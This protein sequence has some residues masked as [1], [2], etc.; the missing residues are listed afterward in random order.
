MNGYKADI[1]SSDLNPTVFTA[2]ASLM[3]GAA[4]GDRNA[5]KLIRLIDKDEQISEK[6]AFPT[7]SSTRP[8]SLP[9]R[10]LN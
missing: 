9:T 7:R 3:G 8:Q 1:L 4:N 5:E 2:R 6:S 10:N